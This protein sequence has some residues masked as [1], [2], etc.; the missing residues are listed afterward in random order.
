VN[1]VL[2]SISEHALNKEAQKP[3]RII[4]RHLVGEF[5]AKK[6][7]DYAELRHYQGAYCAMAA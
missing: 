4:L 7:A 5:A 2:I 6:M 1:F 3:A